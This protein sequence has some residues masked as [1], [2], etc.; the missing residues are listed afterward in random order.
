[1]VAL[2]VDPD[3]DRGLGLHAAVLALL[4]DDTPGLQPEERLVV[5]GRLAPDQEV[6]RPVRRLELE[7]ARLELLD[8]FDDSRRI[9][10]VERQ[11]RLLGARLHGPLAPQLRNEERPA[12]AD[13][14]G[15]DEL[16]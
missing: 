11:A 7:S 10:V 3:L 6:E 12:G 13:G 4:R 15:V 2:A 16:E 5:G 1:Q 9:R 14:G 8:A